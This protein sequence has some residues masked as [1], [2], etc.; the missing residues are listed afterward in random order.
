MFHIVSKILTFFLMPAGIICILLIYAISTKNRT[1]SKK[2]VIATLTF[3]YIFSSPF[4]TNEILLMWEVPPTAISTVKP[5]N[6]GIILTGGTINT[7]RQPAENIFLGGTSDRIGQAL[8][9][10]KLSKIKKILISGGEVP[11]LRKTTSREIDQIVRYLIVSGVP[12]EDIY[13]ED[14]STNTHEN[15]VNTAKL[16]KKQFPNQSYILIT[17][18]FHLKRAIRCFEKAGV[19]VTPYGSNYLS[20]ERQW[21]PTYFLPAGDSI[22]HLQLIF[23]EVIGYITYWIFG[24]I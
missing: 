22:G 17:S 1:K 5:H 8:Q 21:V 4:I 6:I 10:Y 23:R 15:A 13:L 11:I 2:T 20:S 16:L 14:R 18:G 24:W 9:L 12:K 3:F 7:T 19:K